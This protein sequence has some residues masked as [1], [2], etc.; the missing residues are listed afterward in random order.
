MGSGFVGILTL[1]GA[2]ASPRPA[3]LHVERF[4]CS[5]AQPERIPPRIPAGQLAASADRAVARRLYAFHLYER[6][7]AR[8]EQRR[9]VWEALD[10]RSHWRACEVTVLSLGPSPALHHASRMP[11]AYG[12]WRPHRRARAII[13][14]PYQRSNSALTLEEQARPGYLGYPSLSVYAMAPTLVMISVPHCSPRVHPRRNPTGQTDR[15]S[16]EDLP[17]CRL[18]FWGGVSAR[19]A[20]VGMPPVSRW[21][22]SRARQLART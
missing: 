3:T 11:T 5:R 20:L 2:V 9:R 6:D 8:R 18:C 14:L 22:P 19:L 17:I 7:S 10:E 4:P 12:A 1:N 16:R 21:R 15:A 13:A